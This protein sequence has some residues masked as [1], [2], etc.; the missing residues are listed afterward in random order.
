MSQAKALQ[1]MARLLRIS[2]Y[3]AIAIACDISCQKGLAPLFKYNFRNSAALAL[4]LRVTLR[5]L[6]VSHTCHRA[7]SCGSPQSMILLSH[8]IDM[9]NADQFRKGVRLIAVDRGASWRLP[10]LEAPASRVAL[11]GSIPRAE[12]SRSLAVISP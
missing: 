1:S 2:E 3:D 10:G 6:Y 5:Y 9:V 4:P 8:H 12:P 7:A 11:S